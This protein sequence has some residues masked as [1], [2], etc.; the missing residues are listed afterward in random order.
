MICT[1]NSLG[2]LGIGVWGSKRWDRH[3]FKISP[4]WVC[5]KQGLRGQEFPGVA[6]KYLVHSD[7][8]ALRLVKRQLKT[9]VKRFL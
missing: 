8:S 1:E 4:N 6:E 9:D 2:V 3:Y 5:S 7:D